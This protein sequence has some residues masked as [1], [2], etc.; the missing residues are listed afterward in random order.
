MTRLQLQFSVERPADDARTGELL[1][2]WFTGAFEALGGSLRAE[3][4]RAE[5]LA[6]AMLRQ[7]G[8]YGAP[9][10]V[11]GQVYTQAGAGRF[12]VKAYSAKSWASFL[13]GLDAVPDR[14]GLNVIT[15]DVRGLPHGSPAFHLQAELN[16]APGREFAA[17][18]QRWLF[19]EAELQPEQLAEEGSRKAILEFVRAFAEQA[20]PSYGEISYPYGSHRTAFEHAF[21][22]FPDETVGDSRRFLRGYAWLTICPPELGQRLGG[23]SGLRASGAFAEVEPLADGGFLLLATADPASYGI[24][25]AERI[26]PVVA[27]V[28]PPGM[29]G[30]EGYTEKP[31]LVVRRD[32][33]T[34]GE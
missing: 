26:F 18:N 15:L 3:L 2:S 11:W 32:P 14:A 17:I 28:L 13:K 1:R 30:A 29:P 6:D 23:E 34:L 27:P 33:S 22:M 24:A 5:P 7:T 12:R 8:P 21:L 16:D 20:R 4:L 10:D 25:D 31:V 19:L 9:G